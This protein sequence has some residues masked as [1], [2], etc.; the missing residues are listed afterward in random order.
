M[1]YLTDSVN[2]IEYIHRV[3]DFIRK[4]N[5]SID[6]VFSILQYSEIDITFYSYNAD[7]IDL[8]DIFKDSGLFEF[9]CLSGLV[10]PDMIKTED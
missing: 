4:Y 2:N 8:I 6:S 3:N 9:V 10:V 1:A 7:A 5:G